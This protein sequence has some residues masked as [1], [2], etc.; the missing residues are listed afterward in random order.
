MG[1]LMISLLG[2]ANIPWIVLTSVSGAFLTSWIFPDAK[3]QFLSQPKKSSRAVSKLPLVLVIL[4][5]IFYSGLESS[6]G[7]WIPTVAV[8][9]GMT[10]ERGTLFSSIFYL[11]FTAGRFLGVWLSTRVKPETIVFTMIALTA[12]P[13]IATSL[14]GNLNVALTALI[15]AGFFLGPIFPNTSSWVARRTPDFPGGTT[16]LLSAVMGGGFLYPPAIGYFIEGTLINAFAT[17]LLPLL[18]ISIAFFLLG[19]MLWRESHQ[20]LATPN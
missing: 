20:R 5:V 3:W 13:L 15:V 8:N 14:S 18:F 17:L 19:G 16:L 10:L 11:L 7:A 2:S 1:P 12:I 9:S 4:G 6:L